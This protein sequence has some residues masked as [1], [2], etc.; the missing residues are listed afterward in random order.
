LAETARSTPRVHPALIAIAA[1]L[2]PAAGHAWLGRRGRAAIFFLVIAAALA[3]GLLLD[4]N[5]HRPIPGQPLSQLATLGAMGSGATY[6]V[7]RF[8][9][10]YSGDATAPGYEYG[11]A[12]LL[13]AGLMNLLLVL[14]CWDIAAGRK[15]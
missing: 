14:D 15:E 11:T 13:S 4:G 7:L 3:T 6:F 8:V 5:L 10:G 1:W 2:V 12:F 9:V